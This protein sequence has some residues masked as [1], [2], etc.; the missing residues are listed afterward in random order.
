MPVPSKG[1]S[2]SVDV[3]EED[4]DDDEDFIDPEGGF[5][6][7]NVVADGLPKGPGIPTEVL[8]LSHCQGISHEQSRREPALLVARGSH[9]DCLTASILHYFLSEHTHKRPCSCSSMC[10]LRHALVQAATDPACNSIWTE[11][12]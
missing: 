12:F 3:E 4:D 8:P 10:R 7:H 6:C 9:D 5:M 2:R 1:R 11:Q